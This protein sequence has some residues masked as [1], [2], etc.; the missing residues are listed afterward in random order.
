MTQPCTSSLEKRFYVLVGRVYTWS[1]S[2]PVRRLGAL[3]CG[4]L[5]AYESP[6]G[7]TFS[8]KIGDKACEKTMVSCPDNLRIIPALVYPPLAGSYKQLTCFPGILVFLSSKFSP[9]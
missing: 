5:S 7:D 4:V 1:L 9:F 3:K 8:V 2:V 6:P